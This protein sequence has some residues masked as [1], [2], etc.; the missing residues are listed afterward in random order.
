MRFMH[1]VF[2]FSCSYISQNFNATSLQLNTKYSTWNESARMGQDRGQH[3]Q[4]LMEE[5]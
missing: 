4:L 3:L 1:S 2:M 5:Y